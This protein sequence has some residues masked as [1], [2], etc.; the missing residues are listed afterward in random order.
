M[1]D[2]AHLLAAGEQ[3]FNDDRSGISSGSSDDVHG[4]LLWTGNSMWS[5]PPFVHSMLSIYSMRKKNDGEVVDPIDPAL[6]RVLVALLD[7]RQVTRAAVRL[8]LT[9]PALSHA[10]GRLRRR[11][12]DP[13]F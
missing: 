7:E 4:F 6:L 2:G 5:P 10:L 9:Q 1:D 8:G 13:L 11:L 3:G 12:D